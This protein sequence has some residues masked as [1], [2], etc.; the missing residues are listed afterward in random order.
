[1]NEG[2]ELEKVGGR[3]ECGS[4]TRASSFMHTGH[5]PTLVV[6]W[7]QVYKGPFVISHVVHLPTDFVAADALA[8]VPALG[9]FAV[10]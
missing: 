2:R 10:A 7:P 6:V 9:F 1:M 5:V 4:G 3:C 8:T